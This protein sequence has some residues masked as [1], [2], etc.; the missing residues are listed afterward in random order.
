MKGA[1]NHTAKNTNVIK[2]KPNQKVKTKYLTSL[3]FSYTHDKI[4]NGK[5]NHGYQDN[6]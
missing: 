1:N 5:N 6:A 3:S 2:L 4:N